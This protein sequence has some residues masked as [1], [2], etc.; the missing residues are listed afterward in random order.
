MRVRGESEAAYAASARHATAP[1]LSIAPPPPFP[2]HRG[3]SEEHDA[4]DDDV[5]VLGHG[6]AEGLRDPR[7]QLPLDSPVAEARAVEHERLRV[8]MVDEVE[9][10]AVVDVHVVVDDEE[11]VRVGEALV[12]ALR[13]VLPDLLHARDRLGVRL[14]DHHLRAA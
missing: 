2:A 3:G 6:H 4:S 13:H 5:D 8:A 9:Q 7:L 14:E 11:E 1:S 12:Q 10:Q